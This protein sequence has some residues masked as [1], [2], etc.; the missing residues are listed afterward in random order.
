LKPDIFKPVPHE[1]VLKSL[2]KAV[3]Q[4]KHH[5]F[6]V[7]FALLLSIETGFFKN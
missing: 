1:P 7:C 5:V 6:G 3:K 2:G 4:E